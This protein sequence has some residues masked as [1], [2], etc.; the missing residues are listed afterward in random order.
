[1]NC[2]VMNEPDGDCMLILMECKRI[3]TICETLKKRNHNTE[4]KRLLIA[5]MEA[6]TQIEDA[7]VSLKDQA[8]ERS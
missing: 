5:I 2:N 4:D 7:A 6:L 8:K 3:D 1:M